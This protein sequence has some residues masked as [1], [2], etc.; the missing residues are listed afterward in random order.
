M[1]VFENLPDLLLNR[2]D[3]TATIVRCTQCGLLYQNP[4][5][6]L[7]EIIAHYPSIYDLYEPVFENRKIPFLLKQAYEFGM[8]QRIRYITRYKNGGKLLDIG[9]ATGTFLKAIGKRG[10][11]DLYGIEI[12]EYASNIARGH[13]GLNIFTGLLEQAGFPDGYFDVV[14]LWDVLEHLHNPV[15][16][17]REI[18]RILKKDGLL[19]MR[20]PN[21]AS[22]DAKIFGRFW[23]GLE[24]PRH[25]F[26][27][28]PSTLGRA[29]SQTGFKPV[30]TDTFSGG[31][32]TFLLSLRFWL[33]DRPG[34]QQLKNSVLNV[35]HN[36]VLRLLTVPIF[37]FAALF[38][39]GPLLTITAVKSKDAP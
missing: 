17:L 2:L 18:H 38:H 12:S 13:F 1:P 19:V 6:E 9:C 15:G 3:I 21:G 25:L 4:R 30:R 14:T 20:L 5:P 11:W 28:T 29:L 24:A 36:P 22:W 31:Y 8:N 35:L 7:D 23:A 32:P 33:V 34:S 10:D 26:I 39:A 37:Q 27:F 16:T